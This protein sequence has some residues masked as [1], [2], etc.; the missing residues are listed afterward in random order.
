MWPR[1]R[2][3]AVWSERG[4][5]ATE[6]LR[7]L[8]IAIRERGAVVLRGNEW[9]RWDLEVRGGILGGVR[10]LAA[11]EDHGG[12]C[13]FVRMRVWPTWSMGGAGAFLLLAGL[14][15]HAGLHQAWFAGAVLGAA[16][17]VLGFRLLME[18]GDAAAAALDGLRHA[19]A[20]AR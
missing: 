10:V 12:G 3:F 13:Q 9:E 17:L 7:A 6:R 19:D 1:P 16:A 14:A 2:A 20:E 18:S 5:D 4:Q 11:V 8:E 15:G